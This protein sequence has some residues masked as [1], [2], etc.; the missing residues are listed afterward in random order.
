MNSKKNI[1][2]F[3][4]SSFFSGSQNMIINFLESDTL[5][6]YYNVSFAY[7]YSELYENG[8]NSRL[9]N[10]HKVKLFPIQLAD[11]ILIK[12]A[13]KSLF[14]KIYKGFAILF[15]KYY[16]LILNTYLL[17]N[18]LKSKQFDI[19]HINNGGFPGG[20]PCN[21]MVLASK[22]IKT[23][24]VVYVANNTAEDYRFF[25]RWLDFPIDLIIKR[26]VSKFVTGSKYSLEIL[27][28]TLKLP[29]H[30]TEQI[31]NGI[32]PRKVKQNKTQ[33][34][35]ENDIPL[36][37]FVISSIG[38]LEKRKGHIYLLKAFNKLLKEYSNN[39]LTLLLAIGKINPEL[40]NIRDY[41]N[42][43]NLE[44]NVRV[45]KYTINVFDLYSASDLIV[46]PSIA[47]EDLPN[48]ISEAMS[49]GKPLIGTSVAGIPEQI[50]NNK[51]GF[52]VKPRNSE[53]L[54]LKIKYLLMNR[55][56]LKDFSDESLKRFELY[57]K[58]EQ[59][60]LKYIELYNSILLKK[61]I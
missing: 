60:V 34:L 42:L 27:K 28:K 57:F 53:E 11:K 8:L 12:S 49:L 35:K 16:S 59:S 47:N 18:F 23:E 22:F 45:L 43:N 20:T 7:C 6:I 33:F 55:S 3:S 39:N 21:A 10:S 5:N 54:F 50:M 48:V 40:N 26:T 1:L 2:Y 13:K 24:H 30:K 9:R 36:D 46:I 15:Y 4:D 14:Y 38:N 19:I 56:K 58:S 52:I 61:E 17:F 44:M 31:F 25:L 32:K 41:I 29:E 37:S 51:S